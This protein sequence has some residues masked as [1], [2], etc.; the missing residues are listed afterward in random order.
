MLVCDWV[1]L[2]WVLPSFFDQYSLKF[3]V[4]QLVPLCL[5]SAQQCRTM[6]LFAASCAR[7]VVEHSSSA[8]RCSCSPHRVPVVWQS[9]AA[10][11]CIVIALA[12]ARVLAT[13][14]ACCPHLR[15]ILQ[16]QWLCCPCPYHPPRVL[17]T[18]ARSGCAVH[19]R[20]YR[21]SCRTSSS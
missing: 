8:A 4:Q 15:L 3:S 2:Y 17:P 5:C 13:L 20:Y 16:L 14:L 9:T 10:G 21:T 1:G 7:R 6:L 19:G 18:P 12:F 11:S